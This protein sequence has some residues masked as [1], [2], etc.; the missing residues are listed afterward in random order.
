M[1]KS[2]PMPTLHILI[3]SSTI[4]YQDC[5]ISFCGVLRVKSWTGV[6]FI[7]VL[8]GV[9]VCGGLFVI[10][11]HSRVYLKYFVILCLCSFKEIEQ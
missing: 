6:V 11:L 8:F 1:V 7:L 2:M 10:F 3:K 5:V 4:S 9:S